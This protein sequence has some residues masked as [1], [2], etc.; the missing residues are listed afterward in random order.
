MTVDALIFLTEENQDKVEVIS[1]KKNKSK[2]CK[3]FLGG[4]YGRSR[5]RNNWLC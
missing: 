3:S 5:Y 4:S 1:A 2:I